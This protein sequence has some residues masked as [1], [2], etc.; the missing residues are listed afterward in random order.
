[1]PAP[2]PLVMCRCYSTED[3]ILSKHD[4]ED[5]IKSAKSTGKSDYVLIDVREPI[6]MPGSLKSCIDR[7]V[8]IRLGESFL[9]EYFF[10]C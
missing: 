7:V 1:M 10:V 9:W 8:E 5:L 3:H 4:V 2:T 6:G